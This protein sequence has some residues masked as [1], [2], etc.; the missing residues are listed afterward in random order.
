MRYNDKP[1]FQMPGAVR[2]LFKPHHHVPHIAAFAQTNGVSHEF[3]RLSLYRT[4]QG[5][6][7]TE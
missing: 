3:P 2:Q 7:I 1:H 5:A 4:D 6:V